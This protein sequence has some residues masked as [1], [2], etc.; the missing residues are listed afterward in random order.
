MDDIKTITPPPPRSTRPIPALLAAALLAVAMSS[1]SGSD[2]SADASPLPDVELTD[3]ATGEPAGWD[4]GDR[5]MVINLWASWCT[6]CRAEMPAFDRVAT[7]LGD[8]VAIV[9][10]TDELDRDAAL[11]AATEIGVS[12]PLRYDETQALMTE[13]DVTGLPAS[14]FVDADGNVVGRHLGA[15]TEDELLAEIEERHGIAA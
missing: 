7:E 10:V 6:P 14:V 5:P 2:G 9:G 15:L 12:Y 1:C 8:Q 13:L 11:E 3:L 4:Q